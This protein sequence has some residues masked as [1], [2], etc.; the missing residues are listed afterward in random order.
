MENRDEMGVYADGRGS[1][2]PEWLEE[3]EGEDDEE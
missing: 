2:E 3:Q 1:D